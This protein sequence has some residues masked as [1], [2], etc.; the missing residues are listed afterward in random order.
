[1]TR[2]EFIL[3]VE[4]TQ[5]ALRRFLVALCCGDSSLA[6]DIAQDA[7]IKAYL[8]CESFRNA[9]KFN[10][11]IYKIAYNTFLNHYRSRRTFV[12]V[13]EAGRV[14][15]ND[16]ADKKFDYERLYFALESIPEKERMSVLLFYMEGKPVK[17]IAEICG[18]SQEAV[19]QQLTRG[20]RH[21][22]EI[23]ETANL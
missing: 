17:E 22:K 12:T 16:N 11:W 15:S 4:S 13:E 9:E 5:K 21:L 2:E 23:L 1:M 8:S 20:R 6:D 7:F 3:Q 14:V 19:R 18:V 10:A